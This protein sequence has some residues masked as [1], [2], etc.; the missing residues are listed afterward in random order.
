[1]GALVVL[2]LVLDQWLKI[3]IKSNF[4]YGEVRPIFG[5]WFV[6]EYV[7]N[8]GMAFGT[9]FGAKAWHKLALS[10]FRL[11]AIIGIVYYLIKQIKL[12]AKLEFLIALGLVLA[13]AFGNLIDSMMYDTIFTFNGCEQCNWLEGS[14]HYVDCD[15][16][17]IETRHTGFFLANVVD[18]FHFDATWPSWL[19]LIGGAKVFPAI[20]NLADASISIGIMMILFRQRS[21]FPKTKK[22]LN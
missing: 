15:F 16:G 4:Y 7:E 20:W 17:K 11:G 19:P 18:M 8:P 10:L 12:G 21:Y 3:Y 13:G 5:D 6:L 22:D 2:I 14:G 1:M 9:K